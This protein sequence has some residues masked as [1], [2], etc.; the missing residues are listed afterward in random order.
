MLCD[1]MV[2]FNDGLM[3]GWLARGWL[4]GMG[5]AICSSFGKLCV[6]SVKLTF[7]SL[8]LVTTTHF[9]PTPPLTSPPPQVYG[10]GG[11]C[12]QFLAQC[13]SCFISSNTCHMHDGRGSLIALIAQYL[14][15]LSLLHSHHHQHPIVISNIFFIF[16]F[17]VHLS[18]FHL[19]CRHGS[20]PSP[21]SITHLQLHD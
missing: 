13:L 18:S 20:C 19:S 1:V 10:R 7:L 8:S 4:S 9:P 16:F 2:L 5:L 21:V 6:R 11:F 17:F 14:R 12:W 3:A 15:D